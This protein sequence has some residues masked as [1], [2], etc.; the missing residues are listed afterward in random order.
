MARQAKLWRRKDRPGW[1]ATI[2]GVQRCFGEDHAQAL[3]DFRRA[4][5]V[6]QQRPGSP[7]LVA[8]AVDRYLEDVSRRVRAPTLRNYQHALQLWV[9]AAGR[10]DVGSLVAEDLERWL[11]RPA[12]CGS[13]RHAYGKAVKTWAAWCRRRKILISNPFA[14]VRLPSIARRSPAP[15]GLFDRLLSAAGPELRAWLVV[16][17][18]T[19]CRPG[20][21][22]ELAAV[23]VDW[24][25]HTA[26]VRGKRGPRLLGL[27]DRAIEI[28]RPLAERYPEGPLLRTPRGKPWT[29]A[30]I[31]STLKLLRGRSGNESLRDVVPYHA[32]H[33]FWARAHKAGVSDL[34]IAKQLGHTDLSMLARVYSHADHEIMRETAQ[35]ASDG[36]TA[37]PAPRARPRRK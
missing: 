27:S 30:N 18:E 35:R 29:S 1:W 14:D 2:D 23:D 10:R 17:V 25:E 6:P 21:L 12:W 31:R 37:A 11:E 36:P 5:A 26:E 22:E 13:T 9:D 7:C 34:A 32:R 19:G 16:L 33:A 20:E 28:L 8:V 15:D 24:R 3:R 4:K